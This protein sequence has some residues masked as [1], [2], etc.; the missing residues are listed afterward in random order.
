MT[1][2]GRALLSLALMAPLFAPSAAGAKPGRRA[3]PAPAAST[4]V[5]ERSASVDKPASVRAAKGDD[6]APSAWAPARTADGKTIKT[7]TYT[8]GAMDVEGKLKTPQLLYFLNRVKLEL[9]MSAPDKRS[10]M[11]ELAKSADDKSL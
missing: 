7:K 9:D 4:P 6:A 10:F 5:A 1:A 3:R 2:L 8:F 11:K